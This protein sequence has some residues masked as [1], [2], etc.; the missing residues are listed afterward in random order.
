MSTNEA[1]SKRHDTSAVLPQLLAICRQI[2]GAFGRYVG[3]IAA[4][5]CAEAQRAWTHGGKRT[6]PADVLAY[7]G[8][9]SV[10]IPSAEQR[11]AFEN[12]ARRYIRL[13]T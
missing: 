8:L 5:L 1:H 7:I 6:K 11:L 2:D 3:P 12:E 13:T 9:L 10:H 4:E